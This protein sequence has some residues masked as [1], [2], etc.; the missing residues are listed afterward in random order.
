[1]KINMLPRYSSCKTNLL[2]KTYK[3][4]RNKWMQTGTAGV[5]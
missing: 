4:S 3:S 2:Y 5:E 1:M